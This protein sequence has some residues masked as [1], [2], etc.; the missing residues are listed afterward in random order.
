MVGR[1]L[2]LALTLSV[3]AAAAAHAQGDSLPPGVTAKM[4]TDGR[5]L[6]NG[7]GLCMACHG[8]DAKGVPNLGPDLTDAKWLHSKGTYEDLVKQ[9]MAGVAANKSTNGLVMPP[10]GGSQISDEQVK[11]VAAYVWTLGRKK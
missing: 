10:K 5:G 8:G 3:V 7:A 1:K 4:V 11:A 6:F 2:W 9:I